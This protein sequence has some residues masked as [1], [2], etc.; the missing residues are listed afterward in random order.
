MIFCAVQFLSQR[1]KTTGLPACAMRK[2]QAR[3]AS[4]A[5]STGAHDME[6][7]S[8]MPI[9]QGEG[10]DLLGYISGRQMLA[11]RSLFC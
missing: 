9:S 7:F 8:R 1:R 2:R 10:V 4:F 6:I 11:R 3:G 5:R